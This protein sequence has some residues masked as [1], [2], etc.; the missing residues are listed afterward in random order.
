ML[1]CRA[2]A[3]ENS[4]IMP[5][6][7]LI[8]RLRGPERR[9]LNTY[10]RRSPE[11]DEEGAEREFASSVG[12]SIYYHVTGGVLKSKHPKLELNRYNGPK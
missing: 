8:P 1:T 11:C 10:R 2:Y 6:E 3:S 7:I 9:D 4:L 12:D 5:R